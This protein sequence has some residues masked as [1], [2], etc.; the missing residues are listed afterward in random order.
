[1]VQNRSVLPEYGQFHPISLAGLVQPNVPWHLVST[2]KVLLNYFNEVY[3]L[4]GPLFME[5]VSIYSVTEYVF[6]ILW[7]VCVL[8][9]AVD[10]TGVSRTSQRHQHSWVLVD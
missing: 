5:K 2:R 3:T 4:K 1:M 8:P 6:I 9:N 10:Q 7:R